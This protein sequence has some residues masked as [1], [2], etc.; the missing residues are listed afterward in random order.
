MPRVP[1][2]EVGT[3]GARRLLMTDITELD[4]LLKELR[5][6]P[7]RVPTPERPVTYSGVELADTLVEIRQLPA[8]KQL[9]GDWQECVAR[10]DCDLEQSYGLGERLAYSVTNAATRA[11]GGRGCS[12]ATV[13][14]IALGGR[15]ASLGRVAKG[16]PSF[17]SGDLLC[18]NSN[19]LSSV[20]GLNCRFNNQRPVA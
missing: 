13:A 10:G 7:A 15:G 16:G 6:R 12:K 11:N 3:A 20:A 1:K 8:Y 18:H 2:Y 19:C 4:A 14:L 17:F 9:A 5:P